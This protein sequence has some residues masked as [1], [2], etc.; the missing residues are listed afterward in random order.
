[1]FGWGARRA[2]AKR[3]RELERAR[4]AVYEAWLQAQGAY[5]NA[6]RRGDTRDIGRTSETLRQTMNE[7][8]RFGC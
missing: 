2:E 6:C 8:I 5:R 3:Q 7:R 4:Q 1:M